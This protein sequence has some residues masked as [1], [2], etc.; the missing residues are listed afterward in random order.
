MSRNFVANF[1]SPQN[2]DYQLRLKMKTYTVSRGKTQLFGA[3]FTALQRKLSKKMLC[4]RE[5]QAARRKK[6]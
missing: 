4:E 1:Q 5:S 3:V 2:A 6:A